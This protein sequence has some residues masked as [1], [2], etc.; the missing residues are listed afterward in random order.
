MVTTSTWEVN[1]QMNWRRW[2]VSAWLKIPIKRL[3][4]ILLW[5][6]TPQFTEY[7]TQTLKKK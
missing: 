5:A 7:F 2:K 6:M 4:L 1:K 3:N